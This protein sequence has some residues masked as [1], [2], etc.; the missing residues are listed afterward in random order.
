[1]GG[2]ERAKRS[3]CDQGG[4]AKG[5]TRARPAECA[6]PA[7][8]HNL[9]CDVTDRPP[10]PA[11]SLCCLHALLSSI[12]RDNGLQAAPF[13]PQ[14]RCILQWNNRSAL[15]SRQHAWDLR[16]HV[17][18]RSNNCRPLSA[19]TSWARHLPTQILSN[20]PTVS[21][22]HSASTVPPCNLPAFWA[23]CNTRPSR[24]P[25]PSSAASPGRFGWGGTRD[26]RRRTGAHCRMTGGRMRAA[27]WIAP[28]KKRVR[29]VMLVLPGNAGAAVL[30]PFVPLRLP[31][32]AP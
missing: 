18:P 15:L 3:G 8:S 31:L 25:P 29:V 9:P 7:I 13:Y 12:L 28:R 4:G 27:R 14:R 17:G 11:T 16:A 20:S 6:L 26:E 30:L 32:G 22:P 5:R 10:R 1:M 19:P 21:N 2:A 24:A 23:R